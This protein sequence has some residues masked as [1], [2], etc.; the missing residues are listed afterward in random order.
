MP[1]YASLGTVSE[2]TM[3]EEDLIPAFLDT[4][5]GLARDD[6]ERRL[7]SEIRQRMDA[8]VDLEALTDALQEHAPPFC[9]FGAHPGDGADFGFWV[10]HEAI[11][12]AIHDGEIVGVEAGAEWPDDKEGA[13]YVLEIN[14]HGNMTLFCLAD[15][16]EIWSIV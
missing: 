6:A 10:S 9:Y 2:G 12:D 1:D 5:T 4:L 3:R 7:V 11:R 14:D 13:E 8:K 15:R 16:A